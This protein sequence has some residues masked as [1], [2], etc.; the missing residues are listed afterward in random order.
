MLVMKQFLLVT[1]LLMTAVVA[2]GANLSDEEIAKAK[3][4]YVTGCLN[5]HGKTKGEIHP[6]EF[7]EQAWNKW[8]MEMRERTNLSNEDANMVIMYL[9][10]VR[11]GKAELPK[12]EPKKK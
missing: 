4:F 7:T 9:T 3:E 8:M 11:D 6:K 2:R 1:A 12:I 10:A 5:C